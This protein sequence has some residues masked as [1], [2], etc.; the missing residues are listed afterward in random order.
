MVTV[1]F[2]LSFVRSLMPVPRDFLF[3]RLD[4]LNPAVAVTT[5]GNLL[6]KT[7]MAIIHMCL[8]CC[9]LESDSDVRQDRDQVSCWAGLAPPPPRQGLA[10]TWPAIRLLLNSPHVE[11]VPDRPRVLLSFTLIWGPRRHET[12]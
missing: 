11:R 6:K 9:Y 3:H 10:S 1:T 12:I 5:D 4:H 8:L 2:N 7:I